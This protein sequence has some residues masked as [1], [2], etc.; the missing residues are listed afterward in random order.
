MTEHPT[1][2]APMFAN[3]LEDWLVAQRL[4]LRPT[5]LL[6]YESVAQ[7]Y[8]I[9]RFGHRAVHDITTRD[10]NVL[11]A[12]LMN[13]GAV[14]KDSL[15]A[16]SVRHVHI[17]LSRALDSAVL[18]GLLERNPAWGCTV[19]RQ[20]RPRFTAPVWTDDQVQIFLAFLDGH[21]HRALYR[22]AL[23]TGMR[24]AELLGLSWNDLGIADVTVRQGLTMV[25]GRFHVASSK[26]R[27]PRTIS[28]DAETSLLLERHRLWEALKDRS[29]EATGR[30][31]NLVFTDHVG[32]PLDP[33]VITHEFRTLV[34]QSPLP[35]I[36]LHDL[37]HTH[38]TLLLGAGI[39]LHVVSARLGHSARTTFEYYAHA[40][41][42]NDRLAADAFS[43]A[44]GGS[45][46]MSSV[47]GYALQYADAP[48][49]PGMLTRM[50]KHIA[51]QRRVAARVRRPYRFQ[52]DT[53]D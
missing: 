42:H 21:P 23:A 15:C 53:N 33:S 25:A 41:P 17:V 19:P 14:R 6:S 50:P 38:A 26:T 11:Y 27:R 48:W 8:L 24:R 44:V 2:S 16:N 13:G 43:A 39:P 32:G 30:Q 37:R 1:T 31:W 34:A 18:Q 49:N 20:N 51:E 5:T 9:P 52:A 7:S 40:L 10:V 46:A 36:R 45:S 12:D 29:P 4:R 22:L 28:I 35:R 3:F 47:A